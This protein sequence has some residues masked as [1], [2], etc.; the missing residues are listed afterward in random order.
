M[1]PKYDKGREVMAIA[2]Y[3]VRDLLQH[4]GFFEGHYG[5]SNLAGNFDGQGISF[6]IIQFN[7]GQRTLQPVLKQ[8]ISYHEKEF[9]AIFGKEKG[10]I[11]KKVVFEYG[12]RQQFQWGASISNR[13]VV[14]KEWEKPFMEMG[15]SRNNQKCQ[16]D[17]AMDF[18]NRAEDFCDSFGIISTQGLAFVFDHVIQSWSFN[19]MQRIL[20]EIREKED[21]Y[22][23]AHDNRSMP[24]EDRL[25][26]ILDFI[27]D[28]AAHQFKRRSLIKQGYGYYGNKR[29]DISDFGYGSLNYSS[30]F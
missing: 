16:E 18:V 10:D 11:L 23:K 7:F 29:Y 2:S 6:G 27:P 20:R 26:I 8:Y 1:L 3:L 9:Y 14:I 25:S 24:D 30:S 28:D 17:V 5:Y 12:F 13:G 22:R 21:E 4:S 15:R 19:N